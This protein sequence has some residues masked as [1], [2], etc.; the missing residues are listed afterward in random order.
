MRQ[1]SCAWP[2]IDVAEP[3][4]EMAPPL[5]IL[6]ILHAV[7]MPLLMLLLLFMFGVVC[8]IVVVVVIEAVVLFCEIMPSF[9]SASMQFMLVVV[10][11][12]VWVWYFGSLVL[13]IL[14]VCKLVL[15]MLEFV[16]VVVE[17]VV[18]AV[19]V[20]LMSC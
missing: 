2:A 15:F 18:L 11:G 12:C 7:L 13:R 3:A 19:V 17:L 1:V 20:V 10:A 16:V 8:V 6:E 4:I 9:V 14:W 5:V